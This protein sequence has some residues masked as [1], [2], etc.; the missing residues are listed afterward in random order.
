MSHAVSNLGC[1]NQYPMFVPDAHTEAECQHLLRQYVPAIVT[2]DHVEA[3]LHELIS[4]DGGF[5]GRFE[6]AAPRI[7]DPA[8]QRLLI[9]GCAAGS[10]MI[11]ARRYG[12]QEIHGTEVVPALVEIC[13][14][15]L[16]DGEAFETTHYDGLHLPFP[17][18]HFTTIMSGHIIEHTPSPY[19]YMREHM[20]VLAR[21]GWMFLEFP[22]RY[23]LIELHTGVPSVEYLPGPL[24][25]LALRYLASRF[26]PISSR[27]RT[28]YE[29][30]R[31]TLDP[32]SVWQIRSYL[33]RMDF[34]NSKIVHHYA[35]APG[36]VR[37]L[38]AKSDTQA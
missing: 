3:H 30:I 17:D 35:P 19:A 36:Y 12:F 18:E 7:P 21:G 20:R 34:T 24:R 37:L 32:I 1:T 27:R 10:E 6:Y 22:N 2:P 4:L 26:S 31:Q 9:S 14:R 16:A 28:D 13:R 5:V 23:H 15:R 29:T 38:V 33:R 25:S 11:V 8:K